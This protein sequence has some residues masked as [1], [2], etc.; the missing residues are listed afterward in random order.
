MSDDMNIIL[1]QK[2]TNFI[3]IIDDYENCEN[4]EEIKN[5]NSNNSNQSV[6]SKK[7][8]NS[9]KSINF[10]KSDKSLISKDKEITVTNDINNNLSC[11]KEEIFK[12][13]HS[14]ISKKTNENEELTKSSSLSEN[15]VIK[16]IPV[17][18]LIN[19]NK[20]ENVEVKDNNY[21]E[22]NS[23]NY[24][25]KK[26]NKNKEK[27]KKRI[28]NKKHIS[29]YDDD[30]QR[31]KLELLYEKKI[32]ENSKSNSESDNDRIEHDKNLENKTN[33]NKKEEVKNKRSQYRDE[34]KKICKQFEEKCIMESTRGFNIKDDLY[35][36]NMELLSKNIVQFNSKIANNYECFIFYRSYKDQRVILN[37]D[38]KIGWMEITKKGEQN[39]NSKNK[40]LSSSLRLFENTNKFRKTINGTKLRAFKNTFYVYKTN[41][42]IDILAITK[43][44]LI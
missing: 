12:K 17:V 35:Y 6:N 25:K 22:S 31:K 30:Y 38:K 21:D 39:V 5:Y 33:M 8:I 26:K 10:V 43:E 23:G 34:L 40:Y 9:T 1:K 28:N 37:P 16:N 44:L 14:L 7:S 18:N 15:S 20:E 24:I 19:K 27:N 32:N 4:V 41:I 36:I 42:K 2:Y 13:L 29:S 3:K 11:E